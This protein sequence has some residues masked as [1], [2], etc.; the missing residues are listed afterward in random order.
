MFNRIKAHGVAHAENSLKWQGSLKVSPDFSRLAAPK[1]LRAI[2]VLL[3]LVAA[4]STSAKADVVT[5]N[6]SYE[7]VRPYFM[8]PTGSIFQFSIPQFDGRL[9]T[10]L[11][12]DLSW[13]WAWAVGWGTVDTQGETWN[14]HT[15]VSTRIDLPNG[16]AFLTAQSNVDSR[17]RT[18]GAFA[19]QS[20]FNATANRS[21]VDQALLNLFVG[22][23][24]LDLSEHTDFNFGS[25]LGNAVSQPRATAGDYSGFYR[26]DYTFGPATGGTV[27]EPSTALLGFTA[28]LVLASSK[29]KRKT[30]TP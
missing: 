12:A 20:G 19:Y 18:G 26:I 4:I 22:P 13:N 3:S 1:R 11:R 23:G 15:S 29:R 25:T 7:P 14:V 24:L 6:S 21:I 2:V 17:T 28:L 5:I 30:Q 10:L 8:E 16:A 9:G 27:S